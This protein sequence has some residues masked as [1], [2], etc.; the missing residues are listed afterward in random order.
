MWYPT[1]WLEWH[2]EHL[3]DED[4]P[5][6]QLVAPMMNGGVEWTKE[7]AKCLLAA[8]QWTFMVGMAN[9]C[10]ASLMMLNIGQFLDE[11]TDVKDH[12]AWMLAYVRALQCVGE[13]TGGRRWCPC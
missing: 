1:K 9:F 10:P 8:W 7:L 3:K 13:A 6:W 2:I 12:T 11:A 4:I 5:W